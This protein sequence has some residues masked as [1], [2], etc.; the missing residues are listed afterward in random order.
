MKILRI[1]CLDVSKRLHN[2]DMR[3]AELFKTDLKVSLVLTAEQVIML[4]V[5]LYEHRDI[6][7]YFSIC[8]TTGLVYEVF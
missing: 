3:S 1:R 8:I 2:F 7:M 6:F 5:F 4:N